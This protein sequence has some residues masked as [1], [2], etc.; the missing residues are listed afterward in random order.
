MF[1]PPHQK[2]LYSLS[3]SID[4]RPNDPSSMFIC[5]KIEEFG[6]QDFNIPNSWPRKTNCW[7]GERFQRER[8]RETRNKTTTTIPLKT[9]QK[10]SSTCGF[11][12]PCFRRGVCNRVLALSPRDLQNTYFSFI[13]NTKTLEPYHLPSLSFICNA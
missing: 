5:V 2:D 13:Q 1:F 7:V 9:Q 12:I 11:Q 10:L 4:T 8:E 3:W 6:I